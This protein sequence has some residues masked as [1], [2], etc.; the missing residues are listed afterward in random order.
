MLNLF[1][2]I[3]LHEVKLK[4]EGKDHEG[5]LYVGEYLYDKAL[6]VAYEE[7][8]LGQGVVW[9]AESW[10]FWCCCEELEGKVGKVLNTQLNLGRD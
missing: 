10:G 6:L 3:T 7:E 4:S 2:N 1:N 8:Q 9:K 5:Q